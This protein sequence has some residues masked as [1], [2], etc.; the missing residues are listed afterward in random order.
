MGIVVLFMSLAKFDR[1]Q[2]CKYKILKSRNVK[3]WF[4][5]ILIFL[6]SNPI[7][8][9]PLIIAFLFYP[10]ISENEQLFKKRVRHATIPK[11]AN[12]N[13]NSSMTFI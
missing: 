11:P 2:N 12:R 6:F 3:I 10:F 7:E 1:M 8:W 9:N 4:I 13:D 5:T